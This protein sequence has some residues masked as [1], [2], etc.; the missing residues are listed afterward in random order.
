MANSTAVQ[1]A[2]EL[3]MASRIPLFTSVASLTWVLHDYLATVGD[4][5]RYVWPSRWNVGKILFFWNRYYTI[6]LVAFDAAQIHSFSKFRPSLYDCVLVDIL[7]RV[8]GALGLWPIEIIMQLRIYALFNRSKPIAVF[9]ATLFMASIIA[10]CVIL[11][12]N[13]GELSAKIS[14]AKALPIPSCPIVHVE[15]EWAQWVPPTAYEGVLFSFTLWR[16]SMTLAAKLRETKGHVTFK[17]NVA[18][19]TLHSLLV[20]DNL[21]YF[22]GICGLLIFNNVM[23]TSASRIPWFS[24][25]PFH[26]AGG[27]M[28]AR[29]LIHLRKTLAVRQ[30]KVYN[31]ALAQLDKTHPAQLATVVDV[32]ASR[33]HRRADT[34]STLVDDSAVGT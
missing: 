2:I 26:A 29:M 21:L 15:L 3:T 12:H 5:V 17:E 25:G 20:Q 8:F 27:I 18:M 10:F 23:S 30:E 22:L 14:F 13:V 24:F 31:A 28:T 11:A 9:N 1:E 7:T 4:E 16:A 32:R 33:V 6:L 34:E 19:P